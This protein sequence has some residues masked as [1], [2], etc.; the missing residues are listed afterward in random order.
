MEEEEEHLEK[1]SDDNGDLS[2]ETWLALLMTSPDY[3]SGVDILVD[4]KIIQG[5]NILT[6]DDDLIV[7]MFD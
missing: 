2:Q 5:C 6:I 7:K 3:T 4:F 1:E